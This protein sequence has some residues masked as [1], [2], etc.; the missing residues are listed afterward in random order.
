[1]EFGVICLDDN[2]LLGANESEEILQH[3]LRNGRDWNDVNADPQQ[4]REAHLQLKDILAERFNSAVAQ[5]EAEN[6]TSVLIRVRRAANHWDRLIQQSE[7]AIQ[8][9][10]EG[11]RPQPM[12]RA[13][14]TRL[15]NEL[16]NKQERIAELRRSS[17]VEPEVEEV[18]AG[19]FKIL[20]GSKSDNQP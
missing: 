7:K 18:A 4:L 13:R 5:F 19:I 11:G 8:T 3:L 6:E 16:R 12:I 15:E 10:I 1:M 9:M 2:S 14:K 17:Q 20:P